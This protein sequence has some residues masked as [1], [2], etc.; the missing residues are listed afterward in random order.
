MKMK[1]IAITSIALSLPVLANADNGTLADFIDPATVSVVTKEEANI[2][3]QKDTDAATLAFS[4]GLKDKGFIFARTAKARK[5]KIRQKKRKAGYRTSARSGAQ[6]DERM[7]FSSGS[8]QLSQ[9]TKQRVATLADVYKQH[10]EIQKILITGHTDT[11]GDDT[12]NMALSNA[13]AQ[14]VK[15]QLVA[16]GVP[17]HKISASGY[18]ETSLLPNIS[19]TASANRRV[20]YSIVKARSVAKTQ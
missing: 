2:K 15:Q 10:K 4:L 8:S 14:S 20:E 19:G 3:Q 17:A 5:T 7:T 13:R 18:G 16:F 1:Y 9:Q 12:R 11:V 6:I